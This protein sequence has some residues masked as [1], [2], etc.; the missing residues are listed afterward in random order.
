MVFA[1]GV[2]MTPLIPVNRLFVKRVAEIFL[3]FQMAPLMC[4][5]QKRPDSFSRRAKF[6]LDNTQT[7]PHFP[8][9]SAMLQSHFSRYWRHKLNGK[10]TS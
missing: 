5:H 2:F 9:H 6:S 10:E 7:I 1:N 3:K 8:H 4:S